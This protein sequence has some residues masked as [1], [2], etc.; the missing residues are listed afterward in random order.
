MPTW[1]ELHMALAQRRLSHHFKRPRVF[2]R[3]TANSSHWP[4]LRCD[5]PR[6]GI[7][8]ALADPI[9]DLRFA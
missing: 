1:K 3:S 9:V 2:I 7:A 6:T 8:S 4:D 5:K